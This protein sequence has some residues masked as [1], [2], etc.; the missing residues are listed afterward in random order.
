M[1]NYPKREK[2][3]KRNLCQ[4]LPLSNILTTGLRRC[5]HPLIVAVKNTGQKI[6]FSIATQI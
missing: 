4:D 6:S 2:L 3:A 5:F 1:M